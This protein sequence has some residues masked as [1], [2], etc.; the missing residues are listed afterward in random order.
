VTPF[1]GQLDRVLFL[2]IDGVLNSHAWFGLRGKRMSAGDDQ[3]GR[4]VHDLDPRAVARLNIILEQTGAKCVLSSTWRKLRGLELT[5]QALARRGF[6]FELS[7][8]T[9]ECDVVTPGGLYLGKGR[10]VEIQA[11]IDNAPGAGWRTD[12]AVFAIVDDDSDMGPLLPM[13]VQTSTAYGLTD[14]EMV[15]LI[16]RLT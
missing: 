15:R 12:D 16:H 13:L 4:M 6:A 11:W 7:G 2:D 5:Q 14:A 8:A 3:L 9:P 1:V 10:G